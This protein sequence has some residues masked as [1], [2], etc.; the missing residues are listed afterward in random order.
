MIDVNIQFEKLRSAEERIINYSDGME[1][2]FEESYD[3][4]MGEI[5]ARTDREI[6]TA[7]QIEKAEKL[8]RFGVEDRLVNRVLS[9]ESILKIDDSRAIPLEAFKAKQTP[10]G[11]EV[12]A[13]RFMPAGVVYQHAFGPEIA[14]LGRDIYRRVS[15]RRFPIQ[16]IRDLKVKE[17]DG[18]KEQFDRGVSQAKAILEKNLRRAKE[19]V[20]KEFGR[21]VYATSQT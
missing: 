10:E 1:K 5:R 21:D 19:Q 15:K 6:L 7:I 12:Y 8:Q 3:R 2:A 14:K 9:K 13:S 18:V 17:I 16:K 20:N 11:V 4:S